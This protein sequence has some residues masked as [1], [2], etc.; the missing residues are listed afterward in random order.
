[1]LSFLFVF[2][3]SYFESCYEKQGRRNSPIS[4]CW[5]TIYQRLIALVQIKK[6][7]KKKEIKTQ[8]TCHNIYKTQMTQE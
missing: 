1:M 4:S 7:I 6:E 2:H 5:V 3:L 8:Q